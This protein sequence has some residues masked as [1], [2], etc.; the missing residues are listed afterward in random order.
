MTKYGHQPKYSIGEK[1]V[2][3]VADIAIKAL[4]PVAWLIRKFKRKK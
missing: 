1:A 3:F 2:N 4:L